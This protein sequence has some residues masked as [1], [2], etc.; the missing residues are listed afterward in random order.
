M[1][2]LAYII[3]AYKYP[4]QLAR[5][6]S[7]L[8]D[9]GVQFFIHYDKK[10]SD[11]EFRQLAVRFGDM[12]NVHLLKRHKCFWGDFGHVQATIKG[13]KEIVRR[14]VPCDYVILLTAQDYPIKTNEQIRRFFAASGGKS[15]MQYCPLPAKELRQERYG[16]DRIERWHF[17]VFSQR[18]GFPIARQFANPLARL[19]CA[20]L[21]SLLPKQRR[22]PAEFVPFW[23]SSYWCL[24][25]ESIEYIYEFITSHQQFVDFF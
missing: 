11:E 2:Q 9:D 24:T 13:I 16:Y 10:S 21:N 1:I 23:G 7:R 22:F 6:V 8:Q 14:E 15:F 4:G 5:L 12:P 25:R 17:R 18:H 20:L 3:S 19:F